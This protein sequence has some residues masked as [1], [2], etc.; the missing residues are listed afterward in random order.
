MEENVSDS[1]CSI[2]HL[3]AHIF[4]EKFSGFST[5]LWDSECD[6]EVRKRHGTARFDATEYII[7]FL[8]FETLQL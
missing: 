1:P 6:E 4:C 7:Q 3:L 5:D 2:L 8:L